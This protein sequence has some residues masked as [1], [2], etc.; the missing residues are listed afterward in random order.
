MDVSCS[1]L[2]ETKVGVEVRAHRRHPDPT[3]STLANGL[4]KRWKALFSSTAP[5]A[6]SGKGGKASG[7]GASSS[8]SLSATVS[9]SSAE[10]AEAASDAA[11]VRDSAATM[12]VGRG[13]GWSRGQ[14]ASPTR[15]K[16][17]TLT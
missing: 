8:V 9:S 13:N 2:R 16:L 11:V 10:A 14:E 7:A 6:A 15:F 4:L 5:L 1:I 3:I 12:Q 17:Q